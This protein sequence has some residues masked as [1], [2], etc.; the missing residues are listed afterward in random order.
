VR[1]F[2]FWSSFESFHFYDVIHS[3]QRI[4]RDSSEAPR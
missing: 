4:M 2:E 1:S 3:S